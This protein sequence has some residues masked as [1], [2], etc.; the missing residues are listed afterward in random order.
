MT[1]QELEHL[2]R[3]VWKN[4]NTHCAVM[5]GEFLAEGELAGDGVPVF[6]GVEA[7]LRAVNEYFRESL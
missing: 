6:P 3:E 5:V 4:A 7:A 1:E 2:V